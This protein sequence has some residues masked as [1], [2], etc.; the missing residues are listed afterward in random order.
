[1]GITRKRLAFIYVLIG[2][3]IALFFVTIPV[4]NKSGL[5]PFIMLT[6]L[7]NGTLWLVMLGKSLI[8]RAFSFQIMH[9]FFLLFFFF[10]A[11]L[12]QYASKAFP[13]V[14]RLSDDT[15]LYGNIIALVWSLFFIFGGAAVPKHRAINKTTFTQSALALN[16]STVM[17]VVAGICVLIATYDVATT[18]FVNLLAR[19]TAVR[20]RDIESSSLRLLM[21][22]STRAFCAISALYAVHVVRHTHKYKFR[23]LVI[24]ACLLINSFPTALSRYAMASIYGAFLLTLFPKLKNNRFF[25]FA[26]MVGFIVV[27]PFLN[28]FRLTAFEDVNIIRSLL[29]AIRGIPTAWLAGDYDA[30]TMMCLATEYVQLRGVTWFRQ[31][32][33]AILFFVP[34]V[35]WPAKPTGSGGIA[36]AA[37]GLSF[38]NISMP[39]PGEGYMN[40]GLLGVILFAFAIGYVTS[41]IDRAYWVGD[42]YG[43][44]V[45]SI[46][47][48]YPLAM[49]MFFFICRGDLLSS[50]AYTFANIAIWVVFCFLVNGLS[51]VKCF[52]PSRNIEGMSST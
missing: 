7:I 52:S 44:E 18:G 4:G 5:N 10:F 35:L 43:D 6:F 38:L 47:L 17:T 49:L 16:S 25:I 31:L 1:M 34:R 13:W 37:L 24:L 12:L 15:V 46:E 32:L 2:I 23:A 26:F 11:A 14:G 48:I 51:L 30:F 50:W 3:F 21:D 41:R 33:G 19:A 36:G 28:A 39:L 27:L 40:C 45:R 20:G 9:W 8:E 29:N 42:G 22:H